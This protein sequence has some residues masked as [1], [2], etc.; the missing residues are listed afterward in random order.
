MISSYLAVGS[1]AVA[2]M[3]VVFAAWQ[4]ALV[5]R[6]LEL[7][8]R[9]NVATFYQGVSK[10]TIDLEKIFIER[11]DLRPLFYEG[12]EPRDDAQRQ[13]ALSVAAC[14][15]DA[16]EICIAAEKVLP[17]LMGDWD[18]FFHHIFVSSPAFQEYWADLGHLYPPG[19]RAA[20]V[21][22]SRLPKPSSQPA[23]KQKHG[24][25]AGL[26]PAEDL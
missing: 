9:V 20:F 4:A 2:F 24:M 8:D 12:R 11:P 3:A 16:A 6:Q 19:V 14:F 1:A 25:A 26:E 5:R 18:A 17:A 21:G 13:Q 23:V 15:A 7:T 10:V 22:P